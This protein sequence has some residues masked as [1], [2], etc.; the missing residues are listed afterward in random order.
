MA[1]IDLHQLAQALAPRAWT[2][3]ALGSP[4]LGLPQPGLQHPAAQ[5]LHAPCE[6]VFSLQVFMRQLRTKVSVSVAHQL[7]VV[8]APLSSDATVAGSA[9]LA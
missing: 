3:H 9:P 4:T 6:A 1:A 8:L 2:V 5:G 7:H